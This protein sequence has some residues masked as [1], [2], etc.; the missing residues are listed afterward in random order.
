M[1]H[2]ELL[3]KIDYL[4]EY[5]PKE[6]QDWTST[7]I[8]VVKKL[9]AVVELHTPY[10]YIEIDGKPTEMWCTCGNSGLIPYPCPTIQAIEA[11]LK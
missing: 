1:S 6:S 8:F 7:A 2:E 9:R 11:E 3:A 5:E 4:L 10:N